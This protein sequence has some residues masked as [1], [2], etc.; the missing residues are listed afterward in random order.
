MM[1]IK[2]SFFGD[3]MKISQ[4]REEEIMNLYI[5]D[6]DGT[7]LSSEGKLSQYTVEKLNKLLAEGLQFT[8][9]TAR[10]IDSVKK[11]LEPLNLELPIILNN[12]LFVYDSKSNKVLKSHS[13]KKYMALEIYEILLD[14]GIEPIVRV[15]KSNSYKLYY[16]SLQNNTIKEFINNK[17]N[18]NIIECIESKNLKHDDT[19]IL[20]IFTLGEKE[21]LKDAAKILTSKFNMGIDFYQDSY[22]DSYWLEINPLKATKGEAALILKDSFE[23]D[24]IISFGDNLNDLSMF[25]ISDASYAMLN[26]N[27]KIKNH[28]S[29]IIGTNDEDS[30]VKE[31]ECIF[32]EKKNKYKRIS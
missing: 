18:S 23:F 13:M 30:V 19:E 15:K 20:S 5:S 7:L 32:L 27:K 26:G 12:G 29:K 2:N 9:A 10:G 6:L 24:R 14:Y 16:K 28:V 11:I 8:I 1:I 21:L 17:K 22:C 4:N 31:L 25:S 3:K